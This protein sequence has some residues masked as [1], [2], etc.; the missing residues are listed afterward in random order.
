[1]ETTIGIDR[2]LVFTSNLA[3]PLSDVETT[4]Q[5]DRSSVFIPHQVKLKL[6]VNAGSCGYINT[7]DE[8]K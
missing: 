2:S 8:S 5:I 3:E 6:S 7:A 1:M 4:I